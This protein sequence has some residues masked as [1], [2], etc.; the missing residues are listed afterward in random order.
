MKIKKTNYGNFK[1]RFGGL[2][3]LAFDRMDGDLEVHRSFMM[4][5]KYRVNV[6][7]RRKKDCTY[8]AFAC[9]GHFSLFG[10]TD[11]RLTI[12]CKFD[13][14]VTADD[15]VKEDFAYKDTLVAIEEELYNDYYNDDSENEE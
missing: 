6:C 3:R 5:I 10:P 8:V 12:I 11:D 1:E 2:R 14:R 7:Y 4:P 13:G 15:L 9:L